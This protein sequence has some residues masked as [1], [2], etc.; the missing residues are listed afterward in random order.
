M[1]L[2]FK[3]ENVE[4]NTYGKVQFLD[5]EGVSIVC[6]DMETG[7]LNNGYI[8]APQNDVCLFFV[9]GIFERQEN[10]IIY[11]KKISEKYYSSIIEELKRKV[12]R[13]QISLFIPGK[14]YYFSGS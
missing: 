4:V 10:Q 7:T 1:L 3:E 2:K 13:D 12:A 6:G 14:K 5:I 9:F 11:V 8:Y